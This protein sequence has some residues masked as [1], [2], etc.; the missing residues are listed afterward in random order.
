MIRLSSPGPDVFDP[1]YAV[2]LQPERLEPGV[3]L[4]I[5]DA[6]EALVVQV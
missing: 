2:V 4:Q 6:S 5:G 1:L 3:L